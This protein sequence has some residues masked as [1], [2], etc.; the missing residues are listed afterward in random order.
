MQPVFFWFLHSNE[1]SSLEAFRIK[2]KTKPI[3]VNSDKK[4]QNYFEDK[5]PDIS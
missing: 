2:K 1:A 4:W 5:N 3:H